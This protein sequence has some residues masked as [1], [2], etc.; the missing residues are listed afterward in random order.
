MKNL[1]LLLIVLISFSG[2]ISSQSCLPEGIRLETQ[3]EIDN[4]PINY[5]GCTEIEGDVTLIGNNFTDLNGLSAL[6]G[7]GGNLTIGTYS[8]SNPSLTNLTGLE[9]LA[10]IG[11]SLSIGI[12]YAGNPDLISLTGL[13]NLASI[14]GDL[15]I[16]F[17]DT[18]TSLMG[19]D[20]I[21][22]IGGVLTIEN[23]EALTSLS[24]LENISTASITGLYIHDNISLSD[25]EVQSICDY[26]A[27]PDGTINIYNNS[28]GCDNPRELIDA[29]GISLNCLPFGNYYFINQ[30]DID[31]FITY[32]PDCRDLEGDVRIDGDSITNLNGLSAITSIGGNLTIK[33]N[34][35]LT[36]LAGLDSLTFIGGDLYIGEYGDDGNPLLGD[37]TGLNALT[38][39][40]GGLYIEDNEALNSLTGLN[41]LTSIGENLRIYNNDA[42]TSLSGLASLTA[43][44]G[45][46]VIYSNSLLVSLSGLDNINASS[47]ESLYIYGNPNL[48]TCDVQSI[49]E[50]LANPSGTVDVIYND[51]GCDNPP[52]IAYA[53]GFFSPCLPFG[54]Y[55]F[56]Y[57]SEIDNF[58]I[59]YPDCTVLEGSVAIEGYTINNLNGLNPVTSIGGSF[60]IENVDDLT[61]MAGLDNLTSVGG[62][63][64][65]KGFN[66][67]TN[68]SGLDSLSF[69]GGGLFIS[70][71]YYMTSLA[72]L[73]NLTSI[74]GQVE[75]MY[76]SHL[77]NL[78]GMENVTS[79]GA[80]LRIWE[81]EG[82][83]SLDGLDNLTSIGG[84]LDIEENKFLANLSGLENLTSIGGLLR[85]DDNDDLTSLA[86][87][88]NIND[89]SIKYLDIE[90]N[91]LLSSCEVK[92]ICDFLSDPDAILY[93]GYNADG[94]NSP[95]EVQLACEV[96]IG[97]SSVGSRQSAV[98]I[99]PNPSSTQIT[100]ETPETTSKFLISIFNL[101]GEEVISH[102][103][104]A[105]V[106]TI[107]ISQLPQGLYFVKLT[108][109]DTV[110]ALKIVKE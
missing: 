85:I 76:N 46:L 36:S 52:Q 98:K 50:Y 60:K 96:G 105:H 86:G 67:M 77:V 45:G 37:L 33:G 82:F 102:K 87:L 24:G 74:G 6:T 84:D 32:Y 57:Q 5:P 66:H 69:I 26:L 40:G 34:N 103:I 22:F 3:Y 73:D 41:S 89:S 29:C 21:I 43:I 47:I 61:S 71:Q 94:C 101:N 42:L 56:L 55:H 79:I 109:D 95:E 107:D 16:A 39:I 80:A 59:D 14:G 20:S 28:H 92:S 35:V 88:G 13:E 70:G 4:F 15:N 48:S 62:S 11:G 17:N 49:C 44:G 51:T 9:N 19:L 12:D 99:Y 104:T 72:G 18:L 68:L 31:S 108:S 75:F 10:S 25:C 63:F 53:C 58:H 38:S 90:G 27:S 100:I 7:I 106:T 83:T 97:E 91:Y 1:I 54:N 30:A 78:A 81:N 23:N 93:I 8:G 110:T 64:V 2:R 65:I